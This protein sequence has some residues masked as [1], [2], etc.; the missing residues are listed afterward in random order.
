MMPALIMPNA[1]L[2]FLLVSSAAALTDF[3]QPEVEAH[4]AGNS[5]LS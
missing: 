1:C 3:E 2:S 5:Q 4:I